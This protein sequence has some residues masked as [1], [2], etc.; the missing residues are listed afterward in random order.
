[1]KKSITNIDHKLTRKINNKRLS[2]M[3]AITYRSH[4]E[5]P[6]IPTKIIKEQKRRDYVI[7]QQQKLFDKL[8][9]LHELEQQFKDENKA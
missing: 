4:I 9:K 8:K 3:R 5:I 1:M 7:R 2:T 6:H